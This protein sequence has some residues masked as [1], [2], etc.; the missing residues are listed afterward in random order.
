MCNLHPHNYYLEML[1]DLGLIGFSFLITIFFFPVFYLFLKYMRSK[2]Y[3]SYKDNLKF[4][5]FLIIFFCEIFPIRTSGSFFT[6][7]NATV[8]FLFLGIM[9]GEMMKIKRGNSNK[10]GYSK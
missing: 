4:L 5:P 8:L 10:K 2:N 6:T 9:I 3:F 7:S 1:T